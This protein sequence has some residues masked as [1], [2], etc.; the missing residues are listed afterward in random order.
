H[1]LSLTGPLDSPARLAVTDSEILVTDPRN[2]AIV[3]FE[4]DGT[5]LGTWSEPAGPL[6]VAVS[7]NGT[8]YVSRRDDGQVGVYDSAFTFLRFLGEGI[9]MVNF[10]GPTEL[11]ADE[12]SGRIYVVDS[13]GD[14]IYGFESDE[15]LG[16]LLGT[17]GS[18]PGE[19]KYPSALAV[20]SVNNRILVADQDNYRVQVF[21][22]TGIFQ[23]KFGY[24][25]KYT[26]G[27]GIEGWLP[28]TAGLA[29]D[30]TGRIFVADASMGTLRVFNS[31]GTE[32]EKVLNYGFAVGDLRTPC[33]VGFDA[34]GRLLV[35]NS[36]AAGVEIYSV[37]PAMRSSQ[38]DA[39]AFA[40]ASVSGTR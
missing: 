13:G 35:S 11:V 1:E 7:T 17:R 19:F 26:V 40:E 34:T 29:V 21:S 23:F 14:R 39:P 20:D 4:L 27:G 22:P 31:T 24:R 18:G 25:I 36:N 32:L 6:G 37:P 33:A 8:I 38:G 9:P 12:V 28:R 5:Y 15:S 2:D 16:L 10:V 30:A 3:R